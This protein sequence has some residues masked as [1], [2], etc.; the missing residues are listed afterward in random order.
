MQANM[1]P[2]TA[3][4]ERR[5]KTRK[6]PP[7][8]V[9]VELG[10]GN[11]GMLRDL[12]E[13]GFAMRAMM[14]LRTGEKTPF[15]IVLSAAVRIEGLGE[16]LWIEEHG[17][18]VGI[19]F[20]EIS[21]RARPQIQSWLNGTLELS[22]ANAEPDKTGGTEAQ[23][24]DQLRQ[25][26]RIPSVGTESPEPW[27]P[28]LALAPQ[29]AITAEP[30]AAPEPAPQAESPP[31]VEA[32][33]P[34]E[35]EK[36]PEP[37]PPTG[38]ESFPG[39]PDFSATQ[40]AIEITFEAL[41]P[42]P[43]PVP[44]RFPRLKPPRPGVS[45]PI[46]EAEIAPQSAPE[47]PD[48][49]QI[50]IQ[51]PGKE[52][53]FGSNA[54]TF[55]ALDVPA[56][57]RAV[58]GG[59]WTDWFTLPRAMTIMILLALLVALTA[60]HR[61]VG[62]GLIWLGEGMGGVQPSQS[63]PPGPKEDSAT[64]QV[65]PTS[66][67]AMESSPGATGSSSPGTVQGTANSAAQHDG[68]QKPLPA[69]PK[70]AQPPVTPFPGA[71]PGGAA[72]AA[73]ETGLAE[74]SKALQLLHGKNGNADPSEAVRLLWISVEKGNASAELTLAELYWHG[75]G[76]AHNCDQTRILLSAAARKGNADAQKRLQQFQQEGCE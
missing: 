36:A 19:R 56:Q 37:V 24:F 63:A 73:Q 20:L 39:L 41:P 13:E 23:S 22:D 11:G 60:L 45:E 51:P 65:N 10:S 14:P 44:G 31:E 40:E 69:V 2:K 27:H 42:A 35:A 71:S 49:S 7:S 26:L 5:K 75:E 43:V 59:T 6:S 62:G 1:S 46:A 55:E 76:V 67:D 53:E 50:L 25:E 64:G 74:F 72:G 4:T 16:I 38:L 32:P 70:S 58:A 68:M 57:A 29:E 33:V 54:S 21:P 17:R 12:S 52:R 9:Y 30:V 34:A 28:V 47:L 48:I 3:K 15:S 8:L 18:V 61:S 66:P